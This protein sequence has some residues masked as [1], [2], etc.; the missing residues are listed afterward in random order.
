MARRNRQ[1][2]VRTVAPC[3]AHQPSLKI[4]GFELADFLADDFWRQLGFGLKGQPPPGGQIHLSNAAS[5][6]TTTTMRLLSDKN[7]GR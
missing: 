1:N 5:L 7:K 2:G 4:T 6:Q 3:F